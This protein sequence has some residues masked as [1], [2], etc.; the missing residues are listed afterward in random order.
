MGLR[1]G[2]RLERCGELGYDRVP[3]SGNRYQVGLPSLTLT[4]EDGII[5]AMESCDG[6]RYVGSIFY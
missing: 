3:L 4:V 5:T 6:L 2:D 1:V